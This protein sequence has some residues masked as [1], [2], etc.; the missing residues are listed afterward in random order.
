MSTDKLLQNQQAVHGQEYRID[1]RPRTKA[2]K[3][4]KLPMI[5]RRHRPPAV[6]RVHVVAPER[7]RSTVPSA[8]SRAASMNTVARGAADGPALATQRGALGGAQLYFTHEL[9]ASLESV[10]PRWS[11]ARGGTVVR[12]RG[13]GFLPAQ[14]AV[15]RFSGARPVPAFVSPSELRCVAPAHAVRALAQRRRLRRGRRARARRA[16]RVRRRPERA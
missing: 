4:L 1:R 7:L 6:G 5:C 11:P 14:P 9:P 8:C 12:L 10:A 3:D 15:C 13:G 16:I 2:A